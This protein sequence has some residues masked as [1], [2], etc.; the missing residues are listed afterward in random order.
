MTAHQTRPLKSQNLGPDGAG[1][2]DGAALL[3]AVEAHHRRFN[4]FPSEAAYV[5]VVLWDAHAHLMDCFEATPRLAFLSPEPASGKTR[6]LEI[7]ETLVPRPLVTVDISQSALFRS[8][9]DGDQRPTVLFDEID[10]VFGAAAGGNEELRGLINAGYRRTGGVIRAVREGD[11]HVVQKFPVYAALAMGG[12]GDLPDTIMSR[13]VVV[14]MRRRAPNEKV[15]PF[16]QRINEPEGHALRDRLAAWA[17]TVRERIEGAWPELPD[18]VT[19]RPADVWE[20]LLA[21]ADAAGG[22]WPA[23]ARAACLELVN[24]AKANDKGSVG[25]RLLADLRDIF[26]GAERLTS[27]TIIERLT[28]LDDAPWADLDGRPLNTRSLS[29]M[30]GEYV[31][32]TNQPIRPRNIKIGTAVAKGYYADDLADAWSRYCQ[33]VPEKSATAATAATAQVRALFPVAEPVAVADSDPPSTT[34]ALADLTTVG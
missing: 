19:D 1:A 31:T 27:A 2:E 25:I 26:Y 29:R 11:S 33:S 24:A 23:R 17:D 9:S 28:G 6:A 20:P 13:S 14:R 16:R 30:L 4:V 18:G 10:T 12:L 34:P 32:A 7:V 8:V 15:E 22:H 3:D 21:V 5:A